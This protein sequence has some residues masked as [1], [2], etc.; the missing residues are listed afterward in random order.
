MKKR[1]HF[2]MI[3]FLTFIILVVICYGTFMPHSSRKIYKLN[4]GW[5]IELGS[6]IYENVNLREFIKRPGSPIEKG[7]VLKMTKVVDISDDITFP[8]IQFMSKYCSWRVTCNNVMVQEK[9]ADYIPN[10]KF[11]GISYNTVSLPKI[12]GPFTLTLEFSINENAS[13]SY[14]DIPK[15]GDFLSIMIHYIFSNLL[16]LGTGVFLIIFGLSFGVITLI[17]YRRLPGI[18]SQLFSSLLFVDVGVWIL[19]YFRVADLIVSTRG[20]STELE[21]FALYM[22]VPLIYMIIGCTQQHYKDW[23]FMVTAATSTMI[24]LFFMLMH[25][26]GIAHINRTFSYFQGIS[27]ICFIF[28]CVTIGRDIAQKKLEPSD[29]IQLLGLAILAIS[30]LFSMVLHVLE[31]AGVIYGNIVIKIV[32]PLGCLTFV[33]ATL[34]NYFIYISESY[35][36]RKE[37]ESLTHLAYADG[38]TDLP[39]RSRFEKYMNDLDKGNETYCIVSLDLNGLKEI[40]DNDGHAAG[41]KY[42]KEF[43]DIL[44]HCFAEK[45]F[46]ARIGGDEFAAILTK[47][48]IYDVDTMITRLKDALE[49]KNVLYPEFRR[50][51]ATGYAYSTEIPEGDSHAVYLL[52]DKRMYKNKKKMHEKLGIKARL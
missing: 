51:V 38:L 35:A 8:T 4:D 30:F 16:G 52:A 32:I 9:Y 42:L 24:C 26:T 46:I 37:Y 11:I 29:K 7:D 3:A 13:Y 23:I 10:G 5:D 41:D 21:F 28:L 33:F 36:R 48:N 15:Y 1:M 39:N 6:D 31:M 49:V 25:L 27:M 2:L 45:A 22:L 50:S 17:F 19:C 40:N 20:H 12:N 14:F 47:N 44:Q 18:L 34:I 43:A